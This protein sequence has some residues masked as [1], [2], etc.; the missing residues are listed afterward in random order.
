[1]LLGGSLAFLLT[2]TEASLVIGV[3]ASLLGGIFLPVGWSVTAAV[4][5]A[6]VT[7]LLYG[8]EIGVRGEDGL[9]DPFL[10]IAVVVVLTAQILVILLGRFM[11]HSMRSRR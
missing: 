3:L 4:G 9:I 7:I 2:F 8:F 1:M 10:P 5:A 11:G 6:M